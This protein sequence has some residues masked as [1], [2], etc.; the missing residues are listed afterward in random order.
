MVYLSTHRRGFSLVELLLVIAI[1]GLLFGLTMPAVQRARE[2]ANAVSCLNNLHEIGIAMNAFA[3][4]HKGYLP[5]GRLNNESATWAV[6]L[7]PYVERQAEWEAWDLKKPY[8]QQTEAARKTIVPVYF[9]PSRRSP[10]TPEWSYSGDA[11]W[12]CTRWEEG[13]MGP[14]G[15]HYYCVEYYS[16]PHVPGALGDYAA[17]VGTVSV[18]NTCGCY[19]WDYKSNGAF[20]FGNPTEL[21]VNMVNQ[22]PDGTSNT[23]MVGDKNVPGG[24]WGHGGLDSSLYNGATWSSIRAAGELYPL[25]KSTQE[26]TWTFGSTHPGVCHFVFVDGH[27]RAIS[28][29]IRPTTLECLADRNGGVPV[30]DEDW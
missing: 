13:P 4:V 30:P 21:G 8:S 25:A 15:R 11:T 26:W 10:G 24:S 3:E 5:A 22:I 18:V 23:L 7:F 14:C 1:I 19:Y 29:S 17:N 12:S 16:S 27:V 2:T 6:L 28:T 20:Q 9:C